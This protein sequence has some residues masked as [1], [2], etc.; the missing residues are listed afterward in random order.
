VGLG[1][2]LLIGSQRQTGV[3]EAKNAQDDWLGGSLAC[4]DVLGRPMIERTIENLKAAGIFPITIVAPPELC[5]ELR[6]PENKFDGVKVEL[7]NNVSAGVDDTLQQYAQD[8]IANA[9]VMSGEIYAETDLL[10]FFYFHREAKKNITRAFDSEGPLDMWV[11][12]C[13]N[14]PYFEAGRPISSANSD[15]ASYFV[16]GYVRRLSDARDLRQIVS[17]ALGGVCAVRPKGREIKSGI[18]VDEGADID[19][20]ARIVAPAYIGRNSIVREDALVTRCS[21]VESN[22]YIDYGTIVEDSSILANTRVGIWLDVNH[23]VAKENKLMSL[24]HDV[25][26]E[27]SDPSLLRANSALRKEAADF[28]IPRERE[29]HADASALQRESTPAPEAWQLGANLIQG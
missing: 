25:L 24:K 11:M 28:S 12:E 17:D 4:M 3:E 14:G 23:A 29:A 15:R 16:A 13:D 2:V 5:A 6:T 20:R 7:S 19:R 9:L 22:C 1:A 8:G 18:W 27:I 10:D 26:L 21:S